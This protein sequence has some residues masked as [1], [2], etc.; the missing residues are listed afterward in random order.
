MRGARCFIRFRD[1]CSAFPPMTHFRITMVKY[2][3]RRAY[4]RGCC[5]RSVG[6]TRPGVI[7]QNGRHRR[8]IACPASLH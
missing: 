3:R 8:D 2:F 6:V 7:C 4:M 5:A 1:G